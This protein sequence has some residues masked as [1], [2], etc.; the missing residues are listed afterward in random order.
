LGGWLAFE[1][2]TSGRF[3]DACR[4]METV[5][6][7]PRVAEADGVVA[8]GAR[9]HGGARLVE[10]DGAWLV[11]CGTWEG[12]PEALLRTLRA[13]KGVDR[14]EGHFAL[15]WYDPAAGRIQVAN[16]TFGRWHVFTA[17]T[18][19]GRMFG[20]SAIALARAAGAEPD[21]LGI[22]EFLSCGT[23]Y[24]DRTPFAKVRRVFKHARDIVAG[25]GEPGDIGRRVRAA[26]EAEVA[27]LERIL[28][29]LTGGLDSRLVVG[30]LGTVED[31]TVT[32]PA[33]SAD[34]VSATRLAGAIG[35][36]M[37][38]IDPDAMLVAK[39][40]FEQVL[41]AASLAEGGYDSIEYAG[42]ARIHLDHARHWGAS[43]N[44]S[45]GEMYRNY[46]WDRSDLGKRIDPVER[47]L[48]RFARTALRPTLLA[49]EHRIDPQA[50]FR[51]VLARGCEPV[52]DLDAWRQ[53]DHLYLA[54][55]MQYW[56][57]S[58]A[59]ATNRIW[60]A[61][62]PLFRRAPLRA[63]YAAPPEV[64]LGSRL[65]FEIIATFDAP[66]RN[67]ALESGFPPQPVSP[68]NA[69]RFLPGLLRVP[70][71]FAARVKRRLFPTAESNP[72]AERIV[73]GLRATGL[74]DW[75]DPQSMA[76]A[77]LLDGNELAALRD[78]PRPPLAVLGRLIATEYAL[79]EAATS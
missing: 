52:K 33:S 54:L 77:P 72:N 38:R 28:P 29:D 65:F 15:A 40:S 44:G 24:E 10:A 74:N 21:P 67:L 76:L 17:E 62:S 70:G 51:A 68:F 4:W 37:H 58:I 45:G 46:W 35:A 43:V 55:R 22:A 3:D 41:D 2:G 47:A 6:G 12:E 19:E 66:F 57:G 42:I 16:D 18:P 5:P 75:L 39:A 48:P 13:G 50:H 49:G 31:V 7:L 79:R 36:K 71:D 27:G 59:G 64:R 23:Y 73:A 53:L 30:A 56:Q 60:P 1:S 11:I 26:V 34:V 14:V 9:E 61:V 63:V 8:F 20:T 69:W 78:A 25:G 32:G